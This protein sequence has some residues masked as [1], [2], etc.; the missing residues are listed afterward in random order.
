MKPG[1]L[2]EEPMKVKLV[3][4]FLVALASWAGTGCAA[5]NQQSCSR[6]KFAILISGM[7]EVR[8][9]KSLGDVYKLLLKKGYSKDNIFILDRKGDKSEDYPVTGPAHYQSIGKIFTRV[10]QKIIE[11]KERNRKTDLFLYVTGHGIRDLRMLYWE[12]K[13]VSG[14]F[15]EVIL[16]FNQ[17]VDE[18]NFAFDVNA[19][20]FD[21]G[22]FVFAQCYSGGFAQRLSGK[23]RITVAASAADEKS[24]DWPRQTSFTVDLLTALENPEADLNGDGKVD[25]PEAFY[26]AWIQSFNKEPRDTPLILVGDEIEDLNL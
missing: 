10:D 24:W 25:I 4:I 5:D 8:F 11:A 20:H 26:K 13:Y 19:I 7:T 6:E 18:I 17:C 1:K 2:K 9:R 14:Y 16:A 15:S 23:N 22:I 21:R 12:G 3:L